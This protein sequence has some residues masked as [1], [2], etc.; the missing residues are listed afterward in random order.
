MLNEI[1]NLKGY[2]YCYTNIL[3]GKKYV[4]QTRYSLRQRAGKDGKGYN[5]Q[6]KFGKAIGNMDEIILNVLYWKL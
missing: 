6:F 3:N 4:G 1:N 2:I 5:T